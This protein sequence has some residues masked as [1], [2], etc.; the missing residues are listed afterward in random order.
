MTHASSA[1]VR[2][3]LALWGTYQIGLGTYFIALRPTLLPEDERAIGANLGNLAAVAPGFPDW[4]DR[5]LVVLGGQAAAAGLLLLAV[6]AL[7]RA[8]PHRLAG[9]GLV[10]AA[11]LP[12]VA[13]MSFINFQIGSD[14]RWALLIPVAIWVA[15]LVL[16]SSSRVGD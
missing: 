11:G 6:A 13:L 1:L 3:L 15:A 12:S 8:R 9:A 4:A 14:F 10:G 7:L 16:F 2:G 5:V